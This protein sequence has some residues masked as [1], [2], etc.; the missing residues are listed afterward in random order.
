V[1]R[2]SE[3]HLQKL[4]KVLPCLY[5]WFSAALRCSPPLVELRSGWKWPVSS[6]SI[7]FLCFF[8]TVPLFGDLLHLYETLVQF[9]L[10]SGRDGNTLIGLST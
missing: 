7:R 4:K 3:L 6:A 5:D 8:V 10:H 1:V 9:S 2:C